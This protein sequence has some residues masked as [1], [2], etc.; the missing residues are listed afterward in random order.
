MA[1]IVAYHHGIAVGTIAVDVY[2]ND[3][4][5]WSQPYL[6]SHCHTRQMQSTFGLGKVGSMINNQ[7]V[8]FFVHRGTDGEVY[9]DCVFVIESVEDYFTAE[10]TYSPQHPARHYHFD[11][12]RCPAHVNTKKTYIA[13]NKL[14]FLPSP[15]V[16]VT[17]WIDGFL[18]PAKLSL[19]EYVAMPRRKSHRVVVRNAANIYCRI[20]RA[21]KKLVGKAPAQTLTQV[22][23]KF[24]LPNCSLNIA[25]L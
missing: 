1:A 15:P 6:W 9:C 7:D 16:L 12:G 5:V 4:F 22:N 18:R 2:R 17:P 8:V 3:P 25:L 21:C 20:A 13:N 23:P 14:S 24:P 11:A 19:R 10:A